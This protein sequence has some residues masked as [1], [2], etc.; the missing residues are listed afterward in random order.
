MGTAARMTRLFGSSCS[1]TKR[2]QNSKLATIRQRGKGRKDTF[3]RNDRRSAIKKNERSQESR[4]MTV[5]YLCQFNLTPRVAMCVTSDSL[6]WI[7]TPRKRNSQDF[8]FET[9]GSIFRSFFETGTK[10]FRFVFSYLLHYCN[11][12]EDPRTLRKFQQ[13]CQK[14]AGC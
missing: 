2:S 10:K 11:L 14:I 7:W 13:K 1:R 5:R 4:Q 6:G 8:W 3:S 12:C 9:W